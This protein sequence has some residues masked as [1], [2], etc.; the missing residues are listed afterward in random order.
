MAEN[1]DFQW[2]LKEACAEELEAFC[3]GVQHGRG[4][5]IRR[6]PGGW[7]LRCAAPRCAA[8]RPHQPRL[9]PS[10]FSS[11]CV[12]VCSPS[13]P[14]FH[15]TRCLEEAAD[16]HGDEFGARC[17]KEVARFQVGRRF[18][19]PPVGL[20]FCRFGAPSATQLC[21]TSAQRRDGWFRAACAAPLI[22]LTPSSRHRPLP[23]PLGFFLQTRASKD[24][25][26]NYRLKE[27]CEKEVGRLCPDV[28]G[29]LQREPLFAAAAAAAGAGGGAF[30]G[31]GG[32]GG[33]AG[34]AGLSGR[35]R[36]GSCMQRA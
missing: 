6:A 8:A 19:P 9:L 29:N 28:C 24:F 12:D 30:I 21:P 34:D 7:L 15:Q 1:I 35:K 2:P 5:V 33:F 3:G 22:A 25:R 16:E 20:L 13:L 10:I 14:P 32:G 36:V 31:G 4:R 26:L 11:V 18:L 23:L 17:K 27:A